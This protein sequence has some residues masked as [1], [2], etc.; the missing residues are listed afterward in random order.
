[1]QDVL[2]QLKNSVIKPT[3]PGSGMESVIGHTLSRR[4]LDE[5]A[6]R[7]VRRGEDYTVQAYLPLPQTPTWQGERVSPRSAMLRV[8]AVADGNGSWQV[9]PGGLARLAGKNENMSSMQHGGSSADVWV[10]GD[11]S[12]SKA[13]APAHRATRARLGYGAAAPPP[14]RHQPRGRESFLAGPLHRARRKL[15]APGADHAAMPGR[16]RPDIP[17]PARLADQHGGRQCAGAGHRAAGHAGAPRVRACPDRQ[18]GRHRASRQRGLQPAG[19]QKR[20]L[21]RARA[22]VARAMAHDRAHR[23]RLL[24]ALLDFQRGEP[25][26]VRPA[27]ASTRAASIK[28]RVKAKA[29][30]RSPLTRPNT[31]PSKPCARSNQPAAFSRP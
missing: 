9:L 30:A 6:G 5:W 21:G 17:T 31:P 11:S 7:I 22:P 4:A 19:A 26:P 23:G 12:T 25:K 13:T 3:Y 18:P 20:G 28:A 14:A 15:H 16:R 2:G 29:R 24:P 27:K 10:L 8:F 1:M